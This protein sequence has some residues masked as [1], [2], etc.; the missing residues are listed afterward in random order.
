MQDEEIDKKIKA[1]LQASKRGNHEQRITLI[2]Q[3]ALEGKPE[4][5]FALALCYRDGICLPR[6][7][8]HAEYWL[9][10]ATEQGFPKAII[11]LAGLRSAS[12]PPDDLIKE[13]RQIM[14]KAV[15]LGHI[16]QGMMDENMDFLTESYEKEMRKTAKQV[17][18]EFRRGNTIFEFPA[19]AV[20]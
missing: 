14:T 13:S 3:F 11:A 12:G 7:I 8:R 6:S 15:N 4:W 9:R 10:M 1:A 2:Q 20:V 18:R 19:G 5:M 17:K 16:T